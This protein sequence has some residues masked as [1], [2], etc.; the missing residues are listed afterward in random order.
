VNAR[1]ALRPLSTSS[2]RPCTRTGGGSAGGGS[3]GDGPRSPEATRAATRNGGKSFSEWLRRETAWGVE[4]FLKILFSVFVF[5]GIHHLFASRFA[6]EKA[7]ES[8]PELWSHGRREEKCGYRV[9]AA[10]PDTDGRAEHIRE[11]RA[12]FS[13]PENGARSPG[14]GGTAEMPRDPRFV[15]TV[16]SYDLYVHTTVIDP[17]NQFWPCPAL[18]RTPC[19]GCFFLATDPQGIHRCVAREKLN[20][21]LQRGD[22]DENFEEIR[23]A[24]RRL[25]NTIRRAAG[26]TRPLLESAGDTAR[27]A[28]SYRY[29]VLAAV[30]TEILW[31]LLREA[32]RRAVTPRQKPGRVIPF[33][34]PTMR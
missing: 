3:G 2:R 33:P 14:N 29:E 18:Y 6:N 22:T 15:V 23:A 28:W 5:R 17:Q 1:G 27:L 19:G 24:M 12:G 34:R 4:H 21:F 13:A 7:Y 25:R 8:A 11:S 30:V 20:D 26:V 16:G 32:V 31:A 9:G 10:K